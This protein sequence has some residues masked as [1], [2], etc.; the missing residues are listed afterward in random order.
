MCQFIYVYIVVCMFMSV[1][2]YEE[3]KG[4]VFLGVSLPHFLGE[5]LSLNLLLSCWL[6]WLYGKLG[7]LPVSLLPLALS[8]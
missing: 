7:D 3:V 5:G 2:T 8:L 4:N 1:Y 6:D